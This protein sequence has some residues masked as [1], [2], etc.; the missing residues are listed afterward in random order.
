MQESAPLKSAA[1]D[2]HARKV[3]WQMTPLSVQSSPPSNTIV[4]IE[5]N[6]E[7]LQYWSKTLRSAPFNYTVLESS[8]AQTGLELC[9]DRAI[10]CVLLDL[11]MP[12]SGF[13]VLLELIPNRSHPKI[14]VI[15]LTHLPHPNLWEMAKHNG[16]QAC[17]L[18]QRTS[19]QELH[20]AIQTAITSVKSQN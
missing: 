18:K 2:E 19:A 3:N 15:I 16:A 10:D 5:D 11:D 9:R 4:L 1:T 20:C 12:E 13:H 8:D 6:E 7:E 14:P 17:L